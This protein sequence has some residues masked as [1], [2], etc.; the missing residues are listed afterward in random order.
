MRNGGKPR[1]GA[2]MKFLL[3][4][5]KRQLTFSRHMRNEGLENLIHTRNIEKESDRKKFVQ[6]D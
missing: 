1:T 3:V 2:A 4:I 5:R 6:V